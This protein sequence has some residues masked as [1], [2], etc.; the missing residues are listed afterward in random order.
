MLNIAFR[1]SKYYVD[2]LA[3]NTKRGLRQKVRRG[4]YPA[5]APIGYLNDPRTKTVVVD[6]KKSVVIRRAF[7][8]YAKN[9]SRLE[10]ISNFLAQSGIHTKGGKRFHRDRSLE[11]S[12][13]IVVVLIF[14][15]F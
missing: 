14:I 11:G 12:I 10:D 6:R 8:L 2:S 4:E 3:E 15:L 7:E 13:G 9:G 1:Q 5:L